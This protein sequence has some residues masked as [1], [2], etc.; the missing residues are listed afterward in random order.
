M[1]YFVKLVVSV[2][3]AA[4][5]A[6]GAATGAFGITARPAAGGTVRA[7]AAVAV[8]P[9]IGCGRLA[10][11]NFSGVPDAPAVVLSAGRV[12]GQGPAVCQVAGYIAPQEQFLLML[13]VSGY[14][15]RYLQQGCGGL[16]GIDYLGSVGSVNS[17]GSAAGTPRPWS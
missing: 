14:S 8:T 1:R 5:M 6:G 13:P 3:A 4:G 15:G 10:S 12:T 2:L 9:V 16:C 11:I 7:A 17:A